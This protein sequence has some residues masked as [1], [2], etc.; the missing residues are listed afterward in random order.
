MSLERRALDSHVLPRHV[1][2][3]PRATSV[4]GSV[5]PMIFVESVV[6]PGVAQKISHADCDD[7][8]DRPSAAG[9]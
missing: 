6:G 1:R 5:V 8:D 3:T 4:A 9:A 7:A 2:A